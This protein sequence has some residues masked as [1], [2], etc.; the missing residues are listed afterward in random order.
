MANS[1]LKLRPRL[2]PGTE[3]LDSFRNKIINGGF[4]VWQRGT[5][6]TVPASYTTDRWRL[7]GQ[8]D[9]GVFVGGVDR[10]T[11]TLGQTDVPG[12]PFYHS[13]IQ[14]YV[15]G[16]AGNELGGMLQR[17]E[18]V[19]TLSG[20]Q[21]TVSF[22]AKGDSPG[23]I[24]F[25]LKQLFGSGGSPSV[26]LPSVNVSLSGLGW[27]RFVFTFNLPSI[28]GKTLGTGHHLA[29]R[30]ISNIGPARI[31]G[32]NI[33]API[34]YTDFWYLSNV[35]IEEG[36]ID[37]PR[38]EILPQETIWGLCQRYWQQSYHE[39]IP[40][41]TPGGSGGVEA[42]EADW[43]E[44]YE[45]VSFF[46]QMRTPP[47]ISIWDHS[48][49]ALPNSAYNYG[50]PHRCNA[51][52]NTASEDSFTIYYTAATNATSYHFHWIADAEL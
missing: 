44:G 4:D 10:Q 31:I 18:N 39:T 23:T 40:A 16:G 17:I 6:F 27:E 20:K 45:G 22:W 33:P 9:G 12:N 41:G 15:T 19:R 30:W 26:W 11:F 50:T 42:F 35:Q 38:F 28:A 7:M 36:V 48:P 46:V 24:A 14:S 8:L 47:S 5:S 3:H 13:R 34:L 21:V 1:A 29:A 43:L 49:L 52:F 37:D 32:K 51:V 2:V 25:Q